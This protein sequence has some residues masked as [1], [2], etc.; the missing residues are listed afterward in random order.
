MV[1]Q[2]LLYSKVTSHIDRPAFSPVIFHLASSFVFFPLSR[3]KTQTPHRGQVTRGRAYGRGSAPFQGC[4]PQSPRMSKG[5]P[6]TRE[7]EQGGFYGPHVT[8]CTRDAATAVWHNE[9][10]KLHS[11]GVPK[12]KKDDARPS[13]KKN[14]YTYSCLQ[15]TL[16][17]HS[18]STTV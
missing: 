7:K 3:K 8:E 10:S 18:K 4:D 11:G 16:V 13:E 6:G 14:V 2:C 12:K 1:Y 9:D 5:I 15:E 17:R